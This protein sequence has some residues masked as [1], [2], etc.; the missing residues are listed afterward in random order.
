MKKHEKHLEKCLA[1]ATKGAGRVS[2]NPLVG[3]V[4]LD[5]NGDFVSSGYHQKYGEAHAEVNAIAKA[6]DKTKDGT[7]YVNLEPCSHHGKTPPCTDLIIKSGF[8]RVVIGMKDPNPKVNGKGIKKLEDAGIEVIYGVLEDKCKKLNEI[9]IKNQTQKKPFIAIKTATTL[10]GQIATA[11]GSSKWITSEKSRAYVQKLRNKYDAILTSATT[12][13]ADNPSM[14]CRMKNGR[15]PIRILVDTQFKSDLNSAFYVDNGVKVYVAV[16]KD[17]KNLPANLPSHIQFIK[18]PLKWGHVDLEYLVDELFKIGVMSILIEAGGELNGA[19]IKA[20]LVDKV[21]QFIAP[22][23]CGDTTA[24]PWISGM[25]TSEISDCLNLKITD[26][27]N[28]GLDILLES[29][30]V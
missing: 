4:V 2:P 12:V 18:C 7:I 21:Y 3:A 28:F 26:K 20:G 13:K 9:F 11:N 17:L 1:K 23:L 16:S 24:K 10:D 25:V 19:F 29:Y 22:K 30:F 6:G 27:K 14:T 15:N 5:K 8:K